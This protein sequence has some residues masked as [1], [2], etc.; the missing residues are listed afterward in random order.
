MEMDMGTKYCIWNSAYKA[1]L[2]ENHG[3]ALKIY[4][5]I[6]HLPQVLFNMASIFI[7]IEKYDQAVDYLTKALKI[8]KVRY[9]QL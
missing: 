6:D 3:T 4:T 5:S 2:D 7:K 8:D 9:R 1:Y